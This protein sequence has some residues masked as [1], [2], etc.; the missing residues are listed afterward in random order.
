MTMTIEMPEAMERR[1][2]ERCAREGRS[3]A[4]GVVAAVVAWLGEPPRGKSVRSL[5]G[6]LG[7][8][9]RTVTLEEM[10]RAVGMGGEG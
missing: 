9:G 2:R 10:E 1:V 3:V 7:Y 4:E 5:K 8:R 6:M